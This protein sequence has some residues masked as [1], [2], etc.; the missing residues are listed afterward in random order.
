MLVHSFTPASLKGIIFLASP[1]M[2]EKDQGANYGQQLSVLANSWKQRF[3]GEDVEYVYTIPSKKLAPKITSPTEIQGKSTS[4][5]LNH[6]PTGK[7]DAA[8]A[9][10]QWQ[11]LIETISK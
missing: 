6:W 2:F 5:E 11:R 10:K 7:Q 9:S 8:A 3:G 1:E 4:F